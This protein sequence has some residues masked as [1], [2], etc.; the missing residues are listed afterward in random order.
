MVG[1][2]MWGYLTISPDN[3]ENQEKIP[4]TPS[5][6]LL[7]THVFE[8]PTSLHIV[9][10]KMATLEEKLD[11]IRSPNLQSQQQVRS[12]SVHARCFTC[13]HSY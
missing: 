11:K 10:L 2:Q 1:E 12:Y 3:N 8:A 7:G 6:D 5:Y 13:I 9:F 4:K